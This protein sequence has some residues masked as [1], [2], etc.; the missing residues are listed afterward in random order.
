VR[1]ATPDAAQ[2]ADAA[3]PTQTLSVSRTVKANKQRGDGE[4]L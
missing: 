2:T 4:P 1:Q 3:P